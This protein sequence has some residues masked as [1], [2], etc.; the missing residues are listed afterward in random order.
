M[1]TSVFVIALLFAINGVNLQA[2]HSFCSFPVCSRVQSRTI[3]NANDNPEQ[4]SLH[5]FSNDQAKSLESLIHFGETWRSHSALRNAN[6]NTLES[7]FITV[8]GCIA[9][10][11]LKVEVT[12]SNLVTVEGLADSKV[13]LGILA[14]VAKVIFPFFLFKSDFLLFFLALF[15]L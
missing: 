12:N 5:F 15:I 2:F 6:I 7:G 8:F 9:K 1:L 11:K 4:Q 3:F 14:F 10:V 13:A